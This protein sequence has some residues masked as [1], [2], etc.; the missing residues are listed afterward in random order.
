MEP[1]QAGKG[2]CLWLTGL[3]CSGKTTISHELAPRLVDRGRRIELLD[4]D[5]VRRGLSSDLGFDRSSR[6][7]HAKR[8][9][10][11]AKL[12]ARNGVIP[13]VALISPYAS[14][15]AQARQEVSQFVEVYIRTPVEVCE[16]RDVKGLY[17]R[18]RAGEIHEFTG[19]DD[20]YEVPLRPEIT[21]D[22]TRMT[23]A[24]SADYVLGELERLGWLAPS[25]QSSGRH[26]LPSANR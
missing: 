17:K 9:T 15:R 13:I 22:T 24:E 10:F 23:P 3:P 20:P 4:G 16:Q 7:Q 8:V 11:V 21:V 5:E 26:T 18:A 12:L 1:E 19:V 6:E 14:S 25:P 2:F